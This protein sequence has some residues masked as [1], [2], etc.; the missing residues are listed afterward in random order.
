MLRPRA[1]ARS[2][3]TGM[4]ADKADAGQFIAGLCA[5]ESMIGCADVICG[6]P[7]RERA[8]IGSWLAARL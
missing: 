8:V 1:E 6:R 5:D 2:A 7:S 4:P 3:S